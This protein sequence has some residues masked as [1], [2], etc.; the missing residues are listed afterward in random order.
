MRIEF[1]KEKI[2]FSKK[3]LLVSSKSRVQKFLGLSRDGLNDPN[4]C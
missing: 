3:K 4:H 1:Q 2:T